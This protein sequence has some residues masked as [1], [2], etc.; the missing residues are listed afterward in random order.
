MST[1]TQQIEDILDKRLG[2]GEYSGR[3]RLQKIEA[4]IAALESVRENVE[5]LDALVS[6]V[7][8]Q[9]EEKQGAYF[10]MLS[11]DPEALAQF[12]EVSCKT[13]KEKLTVLIDSLKLLKKRFERE[14]IRIAFIG[15]ER[16]GKSTFIKTIT[17]LNDKVIP[18]YSGNSCTG[19]VSVI[20]NVQRVKDEAGND[21]K[22]KVVAEYYDTPT[23]LAMVNEKL[24]RFFPDGSVKVGRLEQIADLKLPEN[25]SGNQSTK[26]IAEY[27]KFKT[28]VVEN[29]DKYSH[30][31]GVGTRK[32]YDEDEI[33]QH[34]A[35]YEEFD[36]EVPGS[37][38]VKKDDGTVVWQLDYYKYVAVKNVNIYTSFEIE[39]TKKLEL[40]D[41]IGIGSSADSEAIEAEMYRV[42]REDCDGAIDMY[43]PDVTPNYPQEQADL[44]DNL[45]TNLSDREPAKW[46]VYVLNKITSGFYKNASSAESVL[47]T[48]E[49]IIKGKN[50][51]PVAWT[52]AIDGTVF[53]DVRDELV[54][55]LLS[56]IAENLDE[57]D[58]KLI[59]KSDALCKEAYNEC[60]SLIKSANA[61]TSASA[62]YNADALSLFDEKLFKELLKSFGYA[63]NQ[64]DQKGYATKRDTECFQLEQAYSNIISEIDVYIPDEEVILEQFET[65]ALV[66]QNQMFEEY[67]EQMRNDIF[68]AFEDV[69]SKVLHPLQEKVKTDLIE[70]LFNQGLLKNLPT[71]HE[72]PSIEWLSEV[73]DNYVDE[74]KYPNL[75]KALQFILDY[76]INIEGLVEYNVTKSLYILDKTHSEFIP[77]KGEFTEDFEQKASDV[78]QE[79]C[80]RLTP[81]QNR[82][83]EWISSFTLIPSHSFYSRVHKFHVKVMT[84]TDGKEDFRR[85]YRKNMGLIWAGEINA[86][87]K[88]Q[89]AFGDWTERV[90]ELQQVVTSDNFK[91][92]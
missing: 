25:L 22:V 48:A 61:V 11:S 45:I 32:Y 28:S 33:A 79:L 4:R 83:R 56:L 90:K 10:N 51:K 77:Y 7:R 72:T 35:Q 67:V 43:R 37:H 15:R 63:M 70:I 3:G 88:T 31:I 53:N 2:R 6:T 49:N 76:Q 62:G 41:T 39:T 71:S 19:A 8:K 46:V 5:Q 55:P 73:I 87:G 65:G 86:A 81:V 69:N 74:A 40:V 18:A 66:T 14:A 24:H 75:R 42:L 26:V 23:F 34:V 85:F 80:N 21:V 82:L 68:T 30:L 20:H 36:H 16:Q 9:I 27:L 57:L 84:D 12:E 89:K 59:D 64:I 78:W 52:K 17:G 13:A 54:S 91:L 38:E 29:F 47:N 92:N 58:Q 1:I 50:P 44:L 60:L